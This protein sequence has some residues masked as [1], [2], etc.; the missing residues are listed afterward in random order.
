MPLSCFF[1]S[2][3]FLRLFLASCSW[4]NLLS[5][6]TRACRRHQAMGSQISN[7]E[8]RTVKHTGFS[9]QREGCVFLFSIQKAGSGY[10]DNFVTFIICRV[11]PH[12]SPGSL[13]L[14]KEVPCTTC[15]VVLLSNFKKHF[16]KLF[17]FLCLFLNSLTRLQTHKGSPDFPP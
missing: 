17:F 5:Q 9:L 12:P 1:L 2:K 15:H 11:E 13:I 14:L 16:L 6:G 4:C 10:V 8:S 3:W 7:K